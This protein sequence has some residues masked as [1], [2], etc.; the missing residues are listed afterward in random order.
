MGLAQVLVEPR[1][2]RV[3]QDRIH[4]LQGE[5]VWV[6]SRDSHVPDPDH[7]LRGPGLVDEVDGARRRRRRRRLGRY[8]RP[9]TRP[10]LEARRQQLSR[11]RGR[12]ITHNQNAGAIR[13]VVRR[14]EC[15]DAI[16]RECAGRG[17]GAVEGTSVWM[18]APVH[19]RRERDRR[20]GDGVV[21]QLHDLRAP[22]VALA[23]DLGVG[24]GRA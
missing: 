22:Q 17:G 16:P 8:D 20:H 5:V 18:R 14:V 24:E 7:R 2:E 12:D 3:A 4:D 9:P 23:D 21:G 1:R 11:L 19:N 10:P 15:R 6:G 13:L